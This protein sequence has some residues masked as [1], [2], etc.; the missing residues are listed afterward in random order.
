[1]AEALIKKAEKEKGR[2]FVSEEQKA[3]NAADYLEQAANIY[4]SKKQHK[5]SAECFI[6]AATFKLKIGRAYDA[7]GMFKYAG[8]QLKLAKDPSSSKMLSKAVDIFAEMGKVNQAAKLSKELGE[9]C[10]K[11]DDLEDAMLHFERAAD[12]YKA[13][14]SD[15][16]ARQCMERVAHN[17]AR[18][19]PPDFFR[20]AK[21]FQE[22]AEEA[23]STRLGRFNARKFFFRSLLC[24]MA[25][26][27]TIGARAKHGEFKETDFQFGNSREGKF[28]NLLIQALEDHNGTSFSQ[29]YRDYVEISPLDPWH[30][31]VLRQ[32]QKELTGE[33]DEEA[34]A[35]AKPAKAAAA[36]AASAP[37]TVSASDFL[38]K[39]EEPVPNGAAS[40]AA[41]APTASAVPALPIPDSDS[42]D[43]EMDPELM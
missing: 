26:G 13:E 3:S 25:T 42:D 36:A 10:E 38:A 15:A 21:I 34:A 31:A 1:M 28:T 8:I 2:W 22:V 16:H 32:A 41:S 24:T 19:S 17:S 29:A 27:D 30:T 14:G 35:P 9:T 43:E 4:K 37:K 40:G 6:R 7:A 33:D 5:E 18:T 23:L 39:E 20:A 12:L 11:E